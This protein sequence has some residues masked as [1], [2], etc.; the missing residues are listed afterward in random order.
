MGKQLDLTGLVYGK[1]T[2]IEK[3]ENGREWLCECSCGDKTRKPVDVY[4]LKSGKSKSCGC[5]AK[6]F[7]DI[8][9]RSYGRWK[10]LNRVKSTR[11]NAIKWLC[12]C[13]CEN[14]TTR[15]IL[16]STLKNGTS[17]SC[18]CMQKEEG[19]THNLSKTRI[20]RIRMM[21]IQRC[22]NPV[23]TDYTN[24]GQRGIRICDD[25]LGDSGFINF[26]KWANEN[27]YD[28]ELSID[29]I[30]V[31]GNYEPDNCKWA[32]DKEQGNNRRTS[33]FIEFDGVTKTMAQWEEFYELTTDIIGHR[34]RKGMTGKDLIKPVRSKAEKQSGVK[35][36]RWDVRKQK[37]LLQFTE[38]GKQN[39]VGEYINLEDA[40]FAKEEYIKNK[41]Y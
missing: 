5:T 21:M 26:N 40:I 32:T 35:N 38:L 14:K 23:S 28:K 33:V 6:E 19:L 22:Y 11:K 1:W 12:E 20:Y 24:Y 36:I 27:G 30:D 10:V 29:R 4:N 25:W 34:M 2:V 9:G 16:G 37:W 7:E 3:I 41:I 31:N 18:G 13:S 17:K 15:E 8:S 39:L